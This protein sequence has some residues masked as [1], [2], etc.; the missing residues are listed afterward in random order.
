MLLFGS[1]TVCDT[2]LVVVWDLDGGGGVTSNRVTSGGVTSGGVTSGD[3]ISDRF[4]GTA[5]SASS[6][7][8][9]G[10]AEGDDLNG[11]AALTGGA[12][13]TES[14]NAVVSQVASVRDSDLVGDVAVS[15]GSGLAVLDTEARAAALAS[16]TQA[17]FKTGSPQSPH[18]PSSSGGT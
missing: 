2:N 15:S 11:S 5:A 8:G 12:S 1:L 18:V 9:L 7:G 6:A 14:E 10:L 13:S 17:L 16:L 4:V 3:V